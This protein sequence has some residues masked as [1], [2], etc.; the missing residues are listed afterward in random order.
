MYY[1]GTCSFCNK[2][3]SRKSKGR[4]K[5]FCNTQCQANETRQTRIDKWLSGGTSWKHCIPAWV[6]DRNGY[7]A[8]TYGYKCSNLN[9]NITS[10]HGSEIVLECDH[11]DGNSDNN[12]PKNL[13]LLCPNCHSQSPTFKNRNIGNGR[14]FRK[15]DSSNSK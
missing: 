8:R 15:A 2:E 9:C 4:N 5:K 14:R 13:R 12:S 1:Y 6:K 11:I 10:W 7:L 3:L